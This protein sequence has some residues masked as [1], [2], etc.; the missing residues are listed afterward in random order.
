MYFYIDALMRLEQIIHTVCC[1]INWTY[2]NCK[3]SEKNH[4]IE[5][6][7]VKHTVEFSKNQGFWNNEFWDQYYHALSSSLGSR[8]EW[9]SMA[10]D[11]AKAGLATAMMLSPLAAITW[12]VGENLLESSSFSVE[13]SIFFYRK[14]DHNSENLWI[15]GCSNLSPYTKKYL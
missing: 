9:G 1:P 10:E 4:V 8:K 6:I 11:I 14:W 15:V 7:Y 12:T 3:K 2:S 5:S 13:S